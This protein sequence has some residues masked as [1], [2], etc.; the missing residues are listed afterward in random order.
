MNE[1]IENH[2]TCVADSKEIIKKK[3]DLNFKNFANL[4]EYDPSKRVVLTLPLGVLW[5]DVNSDDFVEIDLESGLQVKD[6]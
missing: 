2:V 6:F 3:S 4:T 1:G 5:E